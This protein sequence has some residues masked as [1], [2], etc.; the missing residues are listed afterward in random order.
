MKKFKERKLSDNELSYLYFKELAVPFFEFFIEYNCSDAKKLKKNIDS[1]INKTM[2][3]FLELNS[4]IKNKKFVYYQNKVNLIELKC[5]FDGYNFEKICK[6]FYN[7]SDG[8]IQ[9]YNVNDK[10]LVFRFNHALV[11]GKGAILFIN[12]FLKH[13]LNQK[14][15]TYTNSYTSD[16]DFIKDLPKIKHK[17][18]LS[19]SNVL[20]NKSKSKENII[21][22]QRITLNRK[23]PFILSKII[24]VMSN[25]FKNDNLTFMV[26]T[27][28]SNLKE[29]IITV[30]NLTV[31]LYLDCSNKDDWFKISKSIYNKISNN[32]N[33]N[34]K[35][36]DY[37]LLLKLPSILYRS[38]VKISIFIETKFNR[39]LTS[40]SITSLSFYHNK[41]K[42]KDFEIKSAFILPFYQPLLPYVINILETETRTEV[43]FCSNR[44]Y[45]DNE[46]CKLITDD[47]KKLT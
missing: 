23:T 44:K 26:P 15:D 20:K 38:L 37:G 1:S 5:E 9:L 12:N 41:Y 21:Y 47:I 18:K 30:S 7:E 36:I 3:D 4:Q 42:A 31:P 33:L 22:Y 39:F 16:I 34:I 45:I 14:I 17:R 25:Y 6:C 24:E 43:I 2:K 29:N 46:T 19:Y 8:N 40:G 35:N 11:D 32:D 13:L 28:I 27:N 10:Y